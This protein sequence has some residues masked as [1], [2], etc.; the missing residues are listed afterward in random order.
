MCIQP[1]AD[2]P[3]PSLPGESFEPSDL[4]ID[5]QLTPHQKSQLQELI[6]WS[7]HL[8]TLLALFER[9]RENGLTIGPSKC[10]FAHE[11]IKYLGFKIGQSQLGPPEDKIKAIADIPLPNTKKQLR[12]FLGS[13]SY[14]RRF[15]PN[16]AASRRPSASS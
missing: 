13:A 9:L 3:P 6:E 15:V 11:T 4:D 10:H 5:A 16:F 14:Y 1:D 12:S 2:Y 8:T 7:H